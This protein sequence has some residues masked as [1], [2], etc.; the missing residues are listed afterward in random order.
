MKAIENE[1][2]QRHTEYTLSLVRQ[3]IDETKTIA[4]DDFKKNESLKKRLFFQLQEIGE[5]AGEIVD[6]TNDE[7]MPAAQRNIFQK[8]SALRNVQYQETE[9][10]LSRI[11]NIVK[12]DLPEMEKPGEADL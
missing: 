5:A 9:T 3:I 10:H 6:I 11:W 7:D 4:F 12:Y 8:L 2:I 1:N